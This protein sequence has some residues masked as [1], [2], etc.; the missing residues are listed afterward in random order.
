MPGLPER[1]VQLAD[2]GQSGGTYDLA[3]AGNGTHLDLEEGE[4]APVLVSRC[5][6]SAS[7]AESWSLPDQTEILLTNRRFA[8]LTTAFDQGG[9]WAGFGAVGLIVSSTANAVSKR[10][11]ARRSA[12]KVAVGHVRHEWVNAVRLRRR[13]S[14]LGMVDTYVDLVLTTAQGQVIVELWGKGVADE[15]F[16]SWLVKI[17][18]YERLMLAGEVLPA[19]DVAALRQLADGGGGDTAWRMGPDTSGTKWVLPG[20]TSTLVASALRSRTPKETLS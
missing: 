20:D 12:G 10:R 16:A 19:A 11:A 14:L 4:R 8:W 17:I 3:S 5:R 6:V 2:I 1:T 15:K 13:K 18:A 7:G 9:G